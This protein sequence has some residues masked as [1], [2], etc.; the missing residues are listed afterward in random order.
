MPETRYAILIGNRH[1]PF[2]PDFSNLDAA[3][4][5]VDNLAEVCGDP[6]LGRFD[7]ITRLK[8]PSHSEVLDALAQVF[9]TVPQDSLVLVYFSGYVTL[10]ARG[11]VYL[12]VMNTQSDFLAATSVGLEQLQE[13]LANSRASQ[14]ILLLDW[15]ARETDH[16]RGA[17]EIAAG[18]HRFARVGGAYIIAA[19]P[20]LQI[21]QQKR[22]ELSSNLTRYLVEGIKT[23]QADSTGRG[24][25]TIDHLY[26]YVAAQM[27]TTIPHEL[28]RV[29]ARGRGELTVAWPPRVHE[30]VPGVITTMRVSY[31]AI[32]QMFRK[33]EVIPFLGPGVMV[34]GMSGR[35]PN[36]EEL[37]RYLARSAGFTESNEPLTLMSQKIHIVAGRGVVYDNLRDIY[38]PEPYGYNPALTHYFLACLPH[39]LLVLSTAYDTLLEDAFD[40]VGKKYAVVTHILHAENDADRGKV[41]VQYSTDKGKAEKCLSDE[42]VIDLSVWSVIYKIHGTFGLCDP[43]SEEEIDSIVISEED[44]IALIT[45]LDNPQTTIPNQ[46]ARQFK[47]RMFLF[48]GY[49]M[50]D[51]NFRAVVDVIHRKGNFRRIQPYVIRAEASEFERLYWESKQVRLIETDLTVFIRDLAEAMGIRL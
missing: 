35:P 31:D 24:Y 34:H 14:V 32:I 10:D 13:V 30:V 25:I 15:C 17:E 28:L 26:Q 51:W 33:G 47:K 5:D 45:M 20:V 42:L 23:G 41:V 19:P 36:P 11:R 12:A 39:P 8:N 2:D 3:E 7:V 49:H 37:T 22:S 18:V 46:L 16:R 27:S 4:H 48:L 9:L 40:E 44:Y 38:R 21:T 1:Y 29:D 50:S 43:E 6:Q